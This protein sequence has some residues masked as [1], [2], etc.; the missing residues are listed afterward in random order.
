VQVAAYKSRA[1][2]DSL[3]ARLRARGYPSHVDGDTTP[4]RVRIGHYHTRADAVAVLRQLKA[5]K[6]D[7]FV[8]EF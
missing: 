2:A 5:K 1:D 7:G 3:A 8:A 4:Y 6:I